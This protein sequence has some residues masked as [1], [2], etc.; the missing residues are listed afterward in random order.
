M[1]ILIPS[2]II[3]LCISYLQIND[4]VGIT[5]QIV[6]YILMLITIIISLLLYK[7]VKKDIITQDLNSIHIEI[8]RLTNKIENSTDEK[9][10]LG[11]NH[12]IKLLKDEI[13]SKY[14]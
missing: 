3:F 5:T 8:K 14:H 12:K 11:L 6:L 13:E 2:I 10:I 1:F 7:K 9:I 4:N